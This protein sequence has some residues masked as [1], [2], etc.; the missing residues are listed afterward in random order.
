MTL[1]IYSA[2]KDI[3]LIVVDRRLTNALTGKALDEES[4]KL[5]SFNNSRQRYRCLVSLT[6][7]ASLNGGVSTINWLA[8]ALP[9]TMGERLTPGV[10]L[11]NL[12]QVFSDKWGS[13]RI[14]QKWKNTSVVFVG[15]RQIEEPPFVHCFTAVISNFQKIDS[16]GN[17]KQFGTFSLSIVGSTPTNETE[18][19]SIGCFG[20]R[21]A[22]SQLKDRLNRTI[23]I[24]RKCK[25]YPPQIRVATQF[26]QQVA[27]RRK[28]GT[29]GNRLLWAAQGPAIQV[30]CGSS[31]LE[32]E[33]NGT[34]RRAMPYV[35]DARGHIAGGIK[36]FGAPRNE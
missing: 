27:Y 2:K 4:Y 6:G 30:V 3:Q 8:T 10:G 29:V 33:K 26:I 14:R 1:I 20:D 15:Y 31:P 13:L 22:A 19:Y 36:I 28:H 23:R 7:L 9:E 11:E 25:T 5:I 18:F 21:S 32:P 24:L 17:P 12:A 34:I 35:V 16:V